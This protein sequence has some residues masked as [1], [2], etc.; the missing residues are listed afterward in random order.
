MAIFKKLL[1]IFLRISISIILLIFLFRQVDERTL[2]G[3]IKNANK[4]LLLLAFFIFLFNVILCLFRWEML[5]KA[6]DIHLPLKRIIISF[7][8]G[9]FFN[10]FLPSTIGGDFMRSLDLAAHTKKPKEVVATVFLDRLS[11]YIGLVIL[12]SLALGFGWKFIQDKVVLFS[13]LFISGLLLVILSVL[14]NNFIYNKINL[15]L[16]S[17]SAGK[18]RD[19][20]RDLHQ[21]IHIFRQHKKVIFQNLSLSFLIQLVTPLDFYLIAISLGIKIPIIYFFVFLPIIGAITLLPISIGGLG[22]RDATTIFFFAKAGVSKDL[23]FAMS[24]LSFSF[25]LIIGA[26]GGLIYVFT[27][28]HRRIQSAQPSAFSS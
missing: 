28:R 19:T 7:S 12:A 23:A 5:L 20:L 27:L 16:N 26:A 1:S 9:V 13:V 21:E 25:I 3:I 24:L 6:A 8:G 14:F 11:G 17:P 15:F 4:P 18:I 22:L 2:F 10:L